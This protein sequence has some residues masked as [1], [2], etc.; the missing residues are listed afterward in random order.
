VTE[1][2]YY[3]VEIK[4]PLA[5]VYLDR[6]DKKN[7]M[8]APAWWDAPSIFEELDKN[9]DVKV[10]IISGKGKSF[11][12]GID[13][14]AMIP[15]LGELM[16]PEQKGGVKWKLIPK[17]KKMQEAMNCIEKCRKPVIAAIHGHCIGA[18]LDMAAACDIRLC[19]EDAVFSLREAA[20]GIVADMGVLQRLPNITGQGIAR[21]LAF[22]AKFIDSKRAKEI[23]LVNQVFET[24]EELMAEAEKM[25]MEIAQDCSSLAVQASKNVLNFGIGKTISEGLDYVASISANI[26]PSDDLFEAFKAFGEKRNPDFLKK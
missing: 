5:M 1:R 12:A 14:M 6:P 10:I 24:K 8:N 15:E 9:N 4:S 21:E 17:I 16:G 20:V 23:H 18:G 26:I 25:A 7:A 13:L 22:T 19:S 11:C 3:S 2:K